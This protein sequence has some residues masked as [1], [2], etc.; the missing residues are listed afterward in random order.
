MTALA[1]PRKLVA[2]PETMI[3]VEDVSKWFGDVVAVS[4]VSFT[5]GPGV[6]ALLGPNGA[7]KSTILRMLCGLTA[8]ARGEVRVPR[9]RSLRDGHGAAAAPPRAVER[10]PAEQ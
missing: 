3:V 4:E 7:G 9:A 10:Q 6:T 2:P 1:V 5:V 8:P